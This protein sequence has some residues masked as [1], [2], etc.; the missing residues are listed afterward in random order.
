MNERITAGDT[1][2]VAFDVAGPVSELRDQVD[3]VLADTGVVLLR[4][5]GVETPERFH[6]VVAHFGD[7]LTS[8]R[9]GNTPRSKVADGVFTS[10]EYPPE[11]EISLHNELSYAGEWPR[12]LFFS[13]LLEP[14]TGGATPVCDGRALLGAL[15]PEV[16]DRFVTRGV[17]YRQHLHGGFGL[18]KS[19]QQTFET[20]DRSEVESFLTEAGLEFSWTDDGGLRTA[21][22]RPAVR[23]APTTGETVWFNQADQWH[24]TNLPPA[25][26]E[27]LLDLYDDEADLPHSAT[28]GDGS[29]IPASDLDAVRAAAK[30]HELAHPW[31]RGD[32]MIVENMLA[33]HGRQPFTGS[34]RVLVSM[35]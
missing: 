11:Y 21:S 17:T 26:R 27:A 25:E 35:T 22:T 23:T 33:L 6:E 30:R 5:L 9:G 32:V 18:G 2:M 19:W 13:C 29:P 7:P 3:K 14:A 28:Y 16:R 12:R 10:T 4:G 15:D 20:E 34:R 24:P 8:Y 31:H 1:T